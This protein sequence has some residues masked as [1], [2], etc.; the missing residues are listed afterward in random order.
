MTTGDRVLL[1]VMLLTGIASFSFAR[2]A[3]KRGEAAAVY[4]GDRLVMRRSLATAGDYNITGKL[5]T[6]ALRAANNSICVVHSNCR[7]KICI[8]QGAISR[9]G[10]AI[11]CVPNH[12]I[13]TIEGQRAKS[14]DAIT[15]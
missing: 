5:G 10:E 1:A 14:G 7:E 13:V 9:R 11:V 15:R 12:L 2:L 6:M 4:V 8:R 3:L